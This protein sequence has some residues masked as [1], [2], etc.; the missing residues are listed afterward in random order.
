MIGAGQGRGCYWAVREFPEGIYAYDISIAGALKAYLQEK[1]PGRRIQVVNAAVYTFQL[2]QSMLLYLETV[3]RFHPDY[4][5]NMD[6]H[7]DLG[8]IAF[9]SPWG[10][11]EALWLDE[12]VRLKMQTE[13]PVRRLKWAQLIDY[14]QA[15]Y[16]ATRLR[17]P[18]CIQDSYD[19]APEAYG[20][21]KPSLQQ[22]SQA[23][24]T[25]LHQYMNILKAD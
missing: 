12:F 7:N 6:G 18:A 19:Y 20:R 15:R 14:L 24:L 22:S 1:L 21:A 3:S 23:F 2:H 5:I 16:L 4:V 9:G 11:T 8:A 17:P 10:F 13:A 25:V